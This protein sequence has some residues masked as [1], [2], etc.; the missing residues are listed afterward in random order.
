MRGREV[1]WVVSILNYMIVSVTLTLAILNY[2]QKDFQGKLQSLM[3]GLGMILSI[4]LRV[5]QSQGIALGTIETNYMTHLRMGFFNKAPALSRTE[6]G[7][8][9]YY[10]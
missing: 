5:E 2:L 8:F 6:G 3:I 4:R 10:L 9:I 1:D 7:A